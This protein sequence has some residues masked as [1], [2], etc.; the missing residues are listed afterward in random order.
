MQSGP[1]LQDAPPAPALLKVVQGAAG[2]FS[3]K[4]PPGVLNFD[5]GGDVWGQ[6][7][8]LTISGLATL[9]GRLAID[10]INSSTLATGDSF[11]ILNF[12]SLTG[13]FDALASTARRARWRA[14]IRGVAR[15]RV[16]ERSDH[17]RVAGP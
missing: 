1:P 15:R 17:H 4:P 12:R 16:S 8:V 6:Y 13:N 3:L 10:L 5:F 11:D 2:T 7:G 9:D 14:P